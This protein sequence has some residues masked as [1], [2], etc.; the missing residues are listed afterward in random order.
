MIFNIIR[1]YY[2]RWSVDGALYLNN[3]FICHTCEHPHLFLPTKRYVIQRIRNVFYIGNMI[4]AKDKRG[5][6]ISK[7]QPLVTFKPSHGPYTCKDGS[8]AVGKHLMNGLLGDV[9]NSY[10]NLH[11]LLCKAVKDNKSITLTIQDKKS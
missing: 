7:F 8:V 9:I 11:E 3:K 6:K 1:Y 2:G 10:S 4:T 5:Q